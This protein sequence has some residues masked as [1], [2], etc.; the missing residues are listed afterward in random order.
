MP[1]VRLSP[2]LRAEYEQLFNT[3][4]LRPERAAEVEALM[5]RVLASQTRYR[6]VEAATG[7]P[8]H[9]VAVTHQMESGGRFDRHLHNGDPL[10][11]RTRQV[12]A[13]RPKAG[14]PPF[15]WEASAADALALHG[16]PGSTDW[17][18]ASLLY[19]TERYNGFG[20]RLYHPQ[21]KSP[22]L[23]SYS[24]HYSAGKYVAD[25][26]W[27]DSAK[28]AQCGAATLLRRLV[29][30][31]HITFVDQPP[32]TPNDAP[33]VVGYAARRP[34]A[35]ATIEQAIQLQRWLNGFAGIFVKVD[36]WPGTKTSDAY[37]Q[38]TGH[39]LPGDPRTARRRARG[40]RPGDAA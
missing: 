24:T 27:S 19:E 21:V 40:R 34:T 5:Q 36:G 23:W 39:F 16:L 18:L 8:W 7:V 26:R 15:T 31:G 37:R 4:D 22:Y 17:S 12:P 29:E 2:A 38:V 13:G 32:P 28:S 30:R 11:A 6:Q 35:A 1:T 33:L 20:Y 3:C 10:T 25:G 14:Q 9:F